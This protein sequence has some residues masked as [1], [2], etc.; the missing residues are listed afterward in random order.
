MSARLDVMAVMDFLVR[1]ADEHYDRDP[2]ES[3]NGEPM[4]P[5]FDASATRAAVA[6]LIEALRSAREWHLGDKY[7]GGTDE[8]QL[9]WREQLARYDDAL[10]RC[11][12][13]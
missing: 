13:V 3:D 6:D 7:R 12:V 10:A 1:L 4:M 2:P 9:A 5:T 8:E 11:G